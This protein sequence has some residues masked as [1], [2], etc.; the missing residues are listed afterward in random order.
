MALAR[1]ARKNPRRSGRGYHMKAKG[2]CGGRMHR[3]K[4]MHGKGTKKLGGLIKKATKRSNVRKLLNTVTK[5]ADVASVFAATQ[6]GKE[7]ASK[8]RDASKML[9]KRKKK[10]VPTMY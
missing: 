7:R 1:A 8:V 4:G 2:H 5:I 6:E 10:A 9:S 3:G